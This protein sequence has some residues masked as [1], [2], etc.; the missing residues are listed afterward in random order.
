MTKFSRKRERNFQRQVFNNFSRV[1]ILICISGK[2]PFFISLVPVS[3]QPR[4]FHINRM[5]IL[6][7]CATF[8]TNGK[9]NVP[10]FCNYNESLQ[11][12]WN[13]D[14]TNA[15]MELLNHIACCYARRGWLVSVVSADIHGVCNRGVHCCIWII[16]SRRIVESTVN[17]DCNQPPAAR[18]VFG[19]SR[20]IYRAIRVCL[21]SL[22][23][24]FFLLL[25]LLF[26]GLD[27]YD[28][29]VVAL[30]W[31]WKMSLVGLR[32]N[33]LHFY[34]S[35]YLSLVRKMTQWR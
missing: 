5:I 28:A 19:I 29:T 12:R 23:C 20:Y 14:E 25:L 24:S 9:R 30:R 35:L 17:I 11:L 26:C 22:L 34:R 1:F 16:A 4:R 27:V 3:P 2:C 21:L 13:Y 18:V 7:K 8:A 32:S 10:H 15:R 6:S 31:N 33:G